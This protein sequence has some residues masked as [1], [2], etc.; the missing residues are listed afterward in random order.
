MFLIGVTHVNFEL[1]CSSMEKHLSGQKESYMLPFSEQM[2]IT[3][4]RLRHN[5]NM[6]LLSILKGISKTTAIRY[7]RNFGK[8]SFLQM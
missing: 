5:L 1:L 3:L 2:Y 6:E 4:L 8:F 7:F